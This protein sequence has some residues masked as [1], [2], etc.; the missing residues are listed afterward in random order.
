VVSYL[1]VVDKVVAHSLDQAVQGCD[2]PGPNV[3]SEVIQWLWLPNTAKGIPPYRLHQ[4]ED[5]Q[6]NLPVG[7]YPMF[8]V[9]HAFGLIVREARRIILTTTV[10]LSSACGGG[11]GAKPA[12]EDPGPPETSASA[13]QG[14]EPQKQ[15]TDAD[16]VVDFSRYGPI[17]LGVSLD[18]AFE[19][20]PGLIEPPEDEQ[21]CVITGISQGRENVWLMIVESRVT[22]VDVYDPAVRTE[23][24]AKIGDSEDR[25]RELY[26]EGVEVQPH[27]YTDGHYLIVAP[28]SGDPYRLIFETNGRTVENFRSGVLPEVAWVEG[29][30]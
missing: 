30:G 24:G 12:P 13:V 9:L 23:R 3:G 19:A 22:R 28:S 21:G 10:L 8:Q 6:G 14:E 26:P 7:G 20:A 29:C 2:S 11:E 16:W 17:P 1:E 4:T 27:K 15:P 25:I 5:S 18:Q